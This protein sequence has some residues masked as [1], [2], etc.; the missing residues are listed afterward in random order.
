MVK[1]TVPL[2]PGAQQLPF[3][4][5]KQSF[6]GFR[7]EPHPVLSH[8]RHEIRRV[9]SET[10]GRSIN[11]KRRALG[12]SLITAFSHGL[13]AV[14]IGEGRQMVYAQRFLTGLR[15]ARLLFSDWLPLTLAAVITVQL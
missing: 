9:I 11:L 4:G 7:R 13:A 8:S 10:E 5:S 6:F 14:L 12:L 3:E 1:P 2:I 15:A